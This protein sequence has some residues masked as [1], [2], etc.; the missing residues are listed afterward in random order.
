MYLYSRKN[1]YIGKNTHSLEGEQNLDILE[2]N[3]FILEKNI[4]NLGN[5]HN[6]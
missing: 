3:K 1:I 4:V 6:F 5:I 2:I